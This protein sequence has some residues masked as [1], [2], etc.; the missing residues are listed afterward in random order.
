MFDPQGIMAMACTVFDRD[1]ATIE[2]GDGPRDELL[3]ILEKRPSPE[4]PTQ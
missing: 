3:D 2:A 1:R 4:L